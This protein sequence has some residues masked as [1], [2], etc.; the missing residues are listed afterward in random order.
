M[1]LEKPD[2]CALAPGGKT[3]RLRASRCA[4]CGGLSFPPAPYGCP[5]CGAAPDRV[6]EELLSGRARLLG[7]AARSHVRTQVRGSP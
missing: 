4:D 7:R 1:E 3:L 6:A 5:A 2:L